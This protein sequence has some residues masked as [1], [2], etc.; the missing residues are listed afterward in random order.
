MG[1]GVSCAWARR[2]RQ[3]ATPKCSEFL[4]GSKRVFCLRV[5]SAAVT[6]AATTGILEKHP[7]VRM[8]GRKELHFF[9]NK[10]PSPRTAESY[11]GNFAR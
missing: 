10:S 2:V 4:V 9:D 8:A 6:G 1:T 11:V 3:T 7:Q 5:L